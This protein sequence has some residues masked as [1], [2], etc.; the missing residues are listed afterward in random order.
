MFLFSFSFFSHIPQ[1]NH[2][3][4]CFLVAQEEK[5]VDNFDFVVV[6]VFVNSLL[7]SFAVSAKKCGIRL[8]S[9]PSLQCTIIL[10]INYAVIGDLWYFP[11]LLSRSKILWRLCLIGTWT[12]NA[13]QRVHNLIS[14][15]PSTIFSSRQNH[16]MIGWCSNMMWCNK[17]SCFLL[18]DVQN[19]RTMQKEWKIS[20]DVI[21]SITDSFKNGNRLFPSLFLC[22]KCKDG[23]CGCS[24]F[25]NRELPCVFS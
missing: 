13:T 3:S 10:Q 1:I 7:L 15:S 14:S 23:L 19:V 25:Y 18:I 16:K 21:V 4:I 20:W 12:W 22:K 11:F 6:V 2:L 9:I 17:R 5:N 24:F 8:T